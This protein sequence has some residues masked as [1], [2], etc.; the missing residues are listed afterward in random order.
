M[1]SRLQALEASEPL[2]RRLQWC[3]LPRRGSL[4]L[5]LGAPSPGPAAQECA[6]LKAGPG[7][8]L[9]FL[10][11]PFPGQR[12][13]SAASLRLLWPGSGLQPARGLCRDQL[14]PPLS[15]HG[16]SASGVCPWALSHS[17]AV[18]WASDVSFPHAGADAPVFGSRQ[19]LRSSLGSLLQLK[20]IR[21]Y[22]E[23]AV[24]ARYRGW[25]CLYSTDPP[26][27]GS[28]TEAQS[29]EVTETVTL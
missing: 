18:S 24:L 23:M 13:S 2:W 29:S 11:S 27:S 9:S 10:L 6:A 22:L 19:G 14:C 20:L 5:T 7:L 16:F 21:R 15:A 25:T 4:E 8:S 17:W 28:K 1:F 3:H 26:S 12:R